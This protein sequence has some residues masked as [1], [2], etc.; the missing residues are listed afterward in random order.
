MTNGVTSVSNS[1]KEYKVPFKITGYI[2]INARSLGDAV[3]EAFNSYDDT[4]L[5]EQGSELDTVIASGYKEV[6]AVGQDN[7]TKRSRG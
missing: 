2:I 7:D 1:Y 4:D 6:S 3:E 5:A